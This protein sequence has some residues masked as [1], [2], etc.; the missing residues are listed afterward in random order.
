LFELRI[1]G[2]NS[3][4]E[5]ARS[6]RNLVKTIEEKLLSRLRLIRKGN[7]K[8]TTQ[9]LPTKGAAELGSREG[10]S[11][12]YSF[13]AP[14]RGEEVRAR[15]H[16]I[17]ILI[18]SKKEMGDIYSVCDGWMSSTKLRHVEFF[19]DLDVLLQFRV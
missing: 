18:L 11:R 8:Q 4:Q 9:P 2:V 16:R 10:P 5:K 14:V 13:R 7:C 19:E 15:S 3:Y 17:S 12:V 6:G 1:W